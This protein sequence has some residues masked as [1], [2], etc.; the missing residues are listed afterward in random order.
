MLTDYIKCRED[1]RNATSTSTRTEFKK[2]FFRLLMLD[3]V[4]NRREVMVNGRS[5]VLGFA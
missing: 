1:Q 3:D 5:Y 4:G 2:P